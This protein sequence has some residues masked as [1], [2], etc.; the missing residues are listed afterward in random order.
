VELVKRLSAIVPP[1]RLH[2]TRYFGAF[3]PNSKLR[4]KIVSMPDSPVPD[5][6]DDGGAEQAREAY[7]LSQLAPPPRLEGPPLPRRKRYLDWAQLLM[8]TFAVD[9]LVCHK[10]GGKKKVEAFIPESERARAILDE[11]GIDGTGHPLAPA[12]RRPEQ[13][14]YCLDAPR[15]DPGIDPTWPD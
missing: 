14:D 5:T 1:P 13:L 12:R 11:L 10:C 15:E 9:V 7:E 6:F 8:R 3:A 2:G 4:A